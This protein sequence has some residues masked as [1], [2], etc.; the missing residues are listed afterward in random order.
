[1]FHGRCPLL[2]GAVLAGLVSGSNHGMAS[3]EVTERAKKFVAEHTRKIRPLDVAAD[4]AWWDANITGKEEDFERKEEAQNEIDGPLQPESFAEVKAL[5][6][7]SPLTTRS[8]RAI[9]VLYLLT[10]RSRSIPSCSSR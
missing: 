9:D 6:E 4:R 1:M 2:V 10:W 5:K 7:K 8:S 3:E